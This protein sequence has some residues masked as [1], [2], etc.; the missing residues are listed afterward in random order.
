MGSTSPSS[1]SDRST[2]SSRPCGRWPTA[3]AASSSGSDRLGLTIRQE[4]LVAKG[5]SVIGSHGYLTSDVE[6]I[7]RWL[8]DGTLTLDGTISHT[9]DL[10]DYARGLATLRDRSAGA[11]RVVIT[12]GA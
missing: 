1:W 5:L 10:A 3:A 7:L 4:T 12:N 8:D 2:S 11:I 9:F 6:Q